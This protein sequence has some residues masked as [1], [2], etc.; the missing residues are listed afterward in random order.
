MA[1][2]LIKLFIS[3]LF[4]LLCRYTILLFQPRKKMRMIVMF[5]G[6]GIFYLNDSNAQKFVQFPYTLLSFNQVCQGIN[7]VYCVK[8]LECKNSILLKTLQWIEWIM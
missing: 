5:D 7:L 2:D 8:N 6:T 3:T 4:I 1:Y